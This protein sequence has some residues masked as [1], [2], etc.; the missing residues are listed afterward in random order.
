MHMLRKI[1]V[2]ALALLGVYLVGRAVAEPF[3]IDV[4]DPSTYMHDWGGPSL[5]GVMAV[6][7]VPGLVS[8]AGLICGSVLRDA[9]GDR[10]PKVRHRRR[11]ESEHGE[12]HDAGV[13][14]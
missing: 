5:V 4:G 10:A 7:M 13:D 1:L 9:T 8:L 2:V 14:L 11:H 12:S 3:V 6:H